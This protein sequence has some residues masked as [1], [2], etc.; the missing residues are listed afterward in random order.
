MTTHQ[1][2]REA[3]ARIFRD[4]AAVGFCLKSDADIV[5]AFIDAHPD[6][7]ADGVRKFRGVGELERTGYIPAG[8]AAEREAADVPPQPVVSG[9][10]EPVAWRGWVDDPTSMFMP[11]WTS[12]SGQKSD[13]AVLKKL[14]ARIEYAYSDSAALAF[15]AAEVAREREACAELCDNF[16]KDIVCPEELAAA[17]R[18]R[19]A[20]TTGETK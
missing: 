16:H 9:L 11:D 17:I 8:S 15:A 2:A 12:W 13:L 4:Q 10:G 14:G 7:P 18:S 19:S 5:E 1:Q 6:A 20:E 3:L